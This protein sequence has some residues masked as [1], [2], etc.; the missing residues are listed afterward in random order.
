M[1]SSKKSGPGLWTLTIVFK[2]KIC[3]TWNS[4]IN[5]VKF[6]LQS[7]V[8][9]LNDSH[10]IILFRTQSAFFRFFCFYTPST[11]FKTQFASLSSQTK[12]IRKKVRIEFGAKLFVSK[13]NHSI[14]CQREKIKTLQ[15]IL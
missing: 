6:E 2:S 13:E 11:L 5:D 4:K 1:H 15:V 7:H 3:V 14:L 12:Q 9:S 10:E 8:L